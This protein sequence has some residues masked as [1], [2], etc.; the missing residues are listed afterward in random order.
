[1][2]RTQQLSRIPAAMFT[3]AG[4]AGLAI[5]LVAAVSACSKA[6][7][8]PSPIEPPPSQTPTVT[9]VEIAG[10]LTVA[11][12]ATSQ[13]SAMATMSDGTTKNVTNQA[14]W[15]SADASVAS[16]SGTGLM[17]SREA[18]TADITALYQGRTARATAQVS[19]AVFRVE[20]TVESVTALN[21]CDDVTQGLGTGEFAVRVLAVQTNGNQ[22]TL[23]STPGYPGNPDN[24]RV[25]E[26]GRNE[27]QTFNT[28]RTFNIPGRSG[29]FLRLQ[30]SA[31]EWDQQV[32]IIPPS[33]RWVP[34]NDMN[35]RSTSRTHSFSGDSFSGLGPNSLTLGNAS[36][37]IRVNYTIS[38]TRQ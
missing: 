38:A 27:S 2:T 21:T 5:L 24:L 9:S 36:C 20:L 1:M 26:L 28:R 14:T 13:L 33:T 34:E 23:V 25:Y 4:Q 8:Q 3:R 35:N 10:D 6:P 18:G 32:V 31:T 17:T 29:E 37:G 12:G 16:V 11:E 22:A 30:F 19:A 15:A 7:G